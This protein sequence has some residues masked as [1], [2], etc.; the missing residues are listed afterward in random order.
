MNVYI[1][2]RESSSVISTKR[3]P[4]VARRP[5][6]EKVWPT[7][8]NKPPKS[9]TPASIGKLT[10]FSQPIAR[11]FTREKVIRSVRGVT[12]VTITTSRPLNSWPLNACSSVSGSQNP[13]APSI[14]NLR[15]RDQVRFDHFIERMIS[16]CFSWRNIAITLMTPAEGVIA[17]SR[18]RPFNF[19]WKCALLTSHK[20]P[21]R[22]RCSYLFKT[23]HGHGLATVRHSTLTTGSNSG[24]TQSPSPAFFSCQRIRL[25]HSLVSWRNIAIALI[26]RRS[27]RVIDSITMP[28]PGPE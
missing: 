20:N 3:A 21:Q 14:I 26:D 19:P 8:M 7:I 5:P 12:T 11:R 18:S 24:W 9:Q 27:K 16:H 17:S 28:A 25:V 4:P 10:Y 13:A 6:P 15:T 2:K 22:V 1:G 23:E